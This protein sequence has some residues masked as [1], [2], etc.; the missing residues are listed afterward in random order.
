MTDQ[1]A[2]QEARQLID[3]Y[4]EQLLE[5]EPILGTEVGD[6]RFDDKLP[7]P[8]EAGR[9]RRE[10]IQREA[11]RR[12]EGID[13]SD[14]DVTTRTT[15]DLLEAIAQRDLDALKYRFD[16]FGAVLHLW[17]PG[18]L[19]A[20]VGS[21]QQADLP[22]RQERYLRRLEAV[23]AYMDEQSKIA[24]EAAAAGQTVPEVVVD[25]SIAQVRRLV[26]GDP[27]HSPAMAP[28]E[29]APDE[30]KERALAILDRQVMPAYERY[31][32]ALRD[33]R[34]R[35]T[36][37]LGLSSLEGGDEMYAAQIRAW[38]TL[39]KSAKEIHQIGLDDLSAIRHELREAAE[40]LGFRDPKAALAEHEASGANRASSREDMVRLAEEQVRRGWDAASTMFSRLPTANCE[41]RPVEEFRE[42][43][44]PFAF[45]QSPSADGS[46][47]GVYYVNTSDLGERP[48][49]HLATTTYHEANPGH[50]FQVSIEQDLEDRP[51]LRRFAGLMA[52]SAFIEGWALYSERLAD[53]M[54]LFVDE[55]ERIGM[56][57]SQG[58][59]AARLVVDTGLHAF[60][61]DRDRAIAQL[62]EIGVPHLDAVIET[63]RYI[64]LP[65]QALA[66]KLGQIE[67]ERWRAE[68]E[69]AEGS[70]FSLKAF[71]DGL[72]A[73]GSLP[74]TVLERELRR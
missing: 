54:E 69:A 6:E 8:S 56:L 1:P 18:S 46:R 10:G 44:M 52:S 48:L 41:V 42:A 5:L 71:H 34:P 14:L 70:S 19:L 20:I 57:E 9:D 15:L 62:E 3:D 60:G 66:Y 61:W 22:E 67:I 73:L 68:A 28:L 24:L 33:Y 36:I 26:D 35:A 17:G 43:D 21:L 13:R 2:R 11:L 38:T 49:H 32:A 29:S 59:R 55:Y 40:R 23:P 12:L 47:P 25:R 4:W 39:D 51:L 45:Y 74:L 30:V 58:W 53:E 50:H 7:D 72:L 16:R 37:T 64:A 65:G 63:D 27:A 31:L